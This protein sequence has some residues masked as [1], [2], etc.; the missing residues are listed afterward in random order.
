M[1]FSFRVCG[2]SFKTSLKSIPKPGAAVQEPTA[3]TAKVL[4]YFLAQMN[5]RYSANFVHKHS[6]LD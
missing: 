4:K 2:N 1:C 5:V 6:L 3:A